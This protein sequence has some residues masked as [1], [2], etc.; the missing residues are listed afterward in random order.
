MYIF[1]QCLNLLRFC[2]DAFQLQT[3]LIQIQFLLAAVKI[4]LY[5]FPIIPDNSLLAILHTAN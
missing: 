2:V 4:N 3:Y 5:F 1:K